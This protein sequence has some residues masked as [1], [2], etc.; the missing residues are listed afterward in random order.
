MAEW[1]RS[2]VAI[3]KRP[4]RN[5]DWSGTVASLGRC[6]VT[7]LTYGDTQGVEV[8]V[9]DGK[10]VCARPR[11]VATINN[12]VDGKAPREGWTRS[13]SQQSDR[14]RLDRRGVFELL[15]HAH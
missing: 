13:R 7:P 9:R 4:I 2:Q 15:Q 11:L 1:I 3:G 5:Q 10:P 14:C 8:P 12:A 6:E